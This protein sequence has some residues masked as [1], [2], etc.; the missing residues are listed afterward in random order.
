MGRMEDN[1]QE[2]LEE[3]LWNEPEEMEEKDDFGEDLDEEEE[4]EE[5]EEI[6]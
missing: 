6:L 1:T 4:E 5:L 2:F 3:H